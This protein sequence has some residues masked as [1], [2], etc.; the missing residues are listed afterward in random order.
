MRLFLLLW[1]LMAGCLKAEPLFWPFHWPW[2][3]GAAEKRE[4]WHFR[5]P[6][7]SRTNEQSRMNAALSPKPTTREEELMHPDITKEFNP[8]AAH[9]GGAFSTGKTELATGEFHFED[10]TRTKTFT[11]RGFSTTEAAGMSATY[12]TKAAPTKESPLSHRGVPVKT[13]AT[14]ESADANKT[15]RTQTLPD[16]DKKFP[17]RGRRQAEI[18]ADVAAGRAPKMPLGGDRDSGQSWSGDARPMTI[19]EVKALLNK[20]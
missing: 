9:F 11:T 16:A 3:K 10:R 2:S 6:W 7:N 15:V 13:Y 17:A 4:A 18:D 8:S 14:R 5:L 12:E 1:L 20:N 19:Q